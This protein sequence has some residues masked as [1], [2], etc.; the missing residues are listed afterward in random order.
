MSHLPPGFELLRGWIR[1]RPEVPD[2]PWS[3]STLK[4]YGREVAAPRLTAWFGAKPYTYS[5]VR[6]E[7]APVPEWVADVWT[8]VETATG[9]VFNSVL[10]NLYRD[11]RDSVAWH[12]DDE[13][14]LGLCPTIASVSIGAVRRF[15][16]KP[17]GGVGLFR[18]ELAHG[19]LLV[20]RG[21]SQRDY[22]H[23]VPKT[24]RQVGPRVNLTFRQVR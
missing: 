16:I 12:A 22:L 1:V 6:H 24:R 23:S 11:G 20:M 3:Q 2:L 15:L 17:R 9:A 19:D 14:E 5:G 13:P 4:I 21:W 8:Q 7:P 10:V 18:T